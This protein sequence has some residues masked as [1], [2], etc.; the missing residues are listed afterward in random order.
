MYVMIPEYDVSRGARPADKEET[1]MD[2]FEK[3]SLAGLVPVI[4]VDDANDA[5]PLCKAL[6]DGGLPVAEITF[7]T[8]AAEEAIRNVAKELPEVMLGAGTVLTVE[9]VKRAVDAGAAYIVSP[10][11]NPTVVGY[12]VENKIPVLPG[13]CNPSDI[14]M[15]MSFGLDT[16][17]FFPAE[18][19]GGIN[20]IKA[21]SAPYGN[22]K[23]VPTGGVNEKNLN[24]YLSFPKVRA[25]GGSW[26]VPGDAIKNKDFAKITELTRSAVKLML[27]LEL[28]HLGINTPSYEDALKTARMLSLLTGLPVD[29]RTKSV[30]VGK[31]YEVMKMPFKGTNGHFALGT[32]DVRRAKWHLEQMGFEFDDASASFKPDGRMA[33]VY[34]KGEF[35]GFAVHLLQK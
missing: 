13:C 27:G 22:M 21:I 10:G 31:E 32:N 33:A 23:F 19:A 28:T 4:K 18:A 12:C 17:K 14:E 35:G 1:Y 11:F 30:F 5:V 6:A 16:V 2:I 15:A 8:D 25:V 24:D 20:F 7:R 9:Q 29:D 34:M 3:L 26:M